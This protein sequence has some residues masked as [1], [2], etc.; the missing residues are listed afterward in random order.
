LVP[1]A[2]IRSMRSRTAS[3]SRHLGGA[4]LAFELLHRARADDRGRHRRVPEDEGDRQVD[5]AEPGLLGE[6]S[7]GVELAPVRRLVL[8]IAL[9]SPLGAA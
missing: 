7:Q 2:T 9:R 3:S 8:P 4:E 1:G 6:H 5:E